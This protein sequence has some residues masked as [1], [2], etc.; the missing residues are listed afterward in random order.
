MNK[1]AL[2]GFV[3]RFQDI[4]DELDALDMS[5][6]LEEAN[7]EF[8]DALFMLESIDP[9]DEDAAEELEEA[10]EELEALLDDYRDLDGGNPGLCECL[11]KFAMCLKMAQNNLC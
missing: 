3:S 10:F 6:E 2:Q 11:E 7:A 8:E 1:K 9:E 5:E 4:L